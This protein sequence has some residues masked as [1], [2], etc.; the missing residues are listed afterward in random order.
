MF[1]VNKHRFKSD[2]Y[3]LSDTVLGCFITAEISSAKIKALVIKEKLF[4]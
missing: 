4:T 1:A 3:I 2:R